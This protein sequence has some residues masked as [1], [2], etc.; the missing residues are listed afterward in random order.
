M[1]TPSV[2]QQEGMLAVAH[3]AVGAAAS[4]DERGR[5]PVPRRDVR[6]QHDLEAV[7]DPVELA[8]SFDDSSHARQPGRRALAATG[9]IDERADTMI[10]RVRVTESEP[11]SSGT[12][13]E[14]E[15]HGRS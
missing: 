10:G 7:L 3:L 4:E 13:E 1:S 15:H 6:R 14:D 9:S 12:G 5:T 11:R 2:H 8:A